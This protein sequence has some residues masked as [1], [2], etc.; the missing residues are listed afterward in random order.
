MLKRVNRVRISFE[1]FC[2][3]IV[4]CALLGCAARSDR[5]SNAGHAL[6]TATQNQFNVPRLGYS[7]EIKSNTNDD[8]LQMEVTRKR[9]TMTVTAFKLEGIYTFLV[10]EKVPAARLR[11]DLAPGIEDAG[12]KKGSLYAVF[13]PA[14]PDNLRLDFATQGKFKWN[15]M[16]YRAS[17]LE[18][19]VLSSTIRKTGEMTPWTVNAQSTRLFVPA[20][21][22]PPGRASA[23]RQ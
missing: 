15:G 4:A 6:D 22:P 20:D 19:I 8:S 18:Q 7:F 3:A 14:E 9:A 10:P 5:F 2:A 12:L 17:I 11:P 13:N 21:K 23:N 16:T 1:I